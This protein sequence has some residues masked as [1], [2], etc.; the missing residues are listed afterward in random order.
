MK[1]KRESKEEREQQ[2]NEKK[3]KREKKKQKRKIP[4]I[5]RTAEEVVDYLE[6][7]VKKFYI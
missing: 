1:K 4:F 6:I 3:E 7:L 2:M 5:E